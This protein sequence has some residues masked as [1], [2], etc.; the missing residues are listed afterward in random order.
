[1]LTRAKTFAARR[2]LDIGFELL[3][4]PHPAI[5]LSLNARLNVR[6]S[7]PLAMSSHVIHKETSKLE[8]ATALID[9]SNDPNSILR[10]VILPLCETPSLLGSVP[11]LPDC[12]LPCG[13]VTSRTRLRVILLWD[14][15]R[16][17]SRTPKIDTGICLRCLGGL[18]CNEARATPSLMAL[19]QTTPVLVPTADTCCADLKLFVQLSKACKV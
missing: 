10:V 12:I 15:D 19:A 1:M 2:S 16:S 18:S 3:A 14:S 5:R 11:S 6:H 8:G 4:G 17:A 9:S 7:K 13:A